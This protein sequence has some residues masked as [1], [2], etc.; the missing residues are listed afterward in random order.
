[1]GE[2]MMSMRASHYVLLD[3][4]M[5][6]VHDLVGNLDGFVLLGRSRGGLGLNRL[7]LRLGFLDRGSRL[8]AGLIVQRRLMLIIVLMLVV[9]GWVVMLIN[10]ILAIMVRSLDWIVIGS[11]GNMPMLLITAV[12]VA[13]AVVV[14]RQMSVSVAITVSIV[15]HIGCCLMNRMVSCGMALFALSKPLLEFFVVF[16]IVSLV[17]V[18]HALSMNRF[19]S[20]LPVLEPTRLD[21]MLDIGVSV[22]KWVS[23]RGISLF[24]LTHFPLMLH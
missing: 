22:V 15:I 4:S 13:A 2:M 10:H 9:R 14:P 20:S 5:A 8:L 24:N 1:M 11:V 12:T 6:M 17:I 3:Y 18:L 16:S 19:M 7:R 23:K 21:K